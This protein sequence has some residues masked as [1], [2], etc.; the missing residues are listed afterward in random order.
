M[1]LISTIKSLKLPRALVRLIVLTLLKEM[2]ET[3]SFP[4]KS[5]ELIL[6]TIVQ[7]MC[8]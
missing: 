7:A 2:R 5:G 1:Q 6:L 3:G 8:K 4:T